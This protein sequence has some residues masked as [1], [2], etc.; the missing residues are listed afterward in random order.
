MFIFV[1]PCRCKQPL[2]WFGG[3]FSRIFNFQ[4]RSQI[5]LTDRDGNQTRRKYQKKKEKKG[6]NITL[7]CD[8][9]SSV[10][11]YIVW[12]RKWGP[13]FKWWCC[14]QKH[15]ES[16][17]WFSPGEEWV[18]SILRAADHKHHWFQWGSLLLWNWKAC[19]YGWETNYSWICAHIW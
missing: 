18:L 10:G 5:W 4:S 19:A 12:Y 15:S 7:H 11:V 8:C 6:E 13:K 17:P 16:I 2:I 3:F 14:L 9:K 1:I